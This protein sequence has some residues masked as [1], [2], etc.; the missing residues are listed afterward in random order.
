MRSA[1]PKPVERLIE[2]FSRLPGIGP[3][4]ASRLTYF[5]LRAPES[6]SLE[7]AEALQEMRTQTRFCSICFNIT[8]ND[9]DPCQICSDG[10]RDSSM[11]CLVSLKDRIGY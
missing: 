5:L 1:A 2:A 9:V 11:I 6:E 10:S 3:K 8:S 7:L 4:T